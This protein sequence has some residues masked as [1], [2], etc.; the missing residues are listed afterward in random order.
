MTLFTHSVLVRK[1]LKIQMALFS[2]LCRTY[3]TYS[4][5]STVRYSVVQHSVVCHLY[6][7]YPHLY[8]LFRRAPT[9]S[10]Q[11]TD[12]FALFS[13]HKIE[14]PATLSPVV[15]SSMLRTMRKI[16]I[17]SC[18]RKVSPNEIVSS[19]KKSCPAKSPSIRANEDLSN[20]LDSIVPQEEIDS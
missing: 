6:I 19:G 12:G 1:L 17:C 2:I 5:Y 7:L 9:E 15:Q 16:F 11:N 3:S 14:N 13:W 4:M 10:I 20:A 8:L 18:R